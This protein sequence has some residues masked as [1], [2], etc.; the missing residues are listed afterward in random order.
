MQ[1]CEDVR[2]FCSVF[3][4]HL[5]MF[6]GSGPVGT[7]VLLLCLLLHACGGTPDSDRELCYSRQHRD[8]TVNVRLALEQK[9][10]VMVAKAKP[11]EKDCILTCCSEDVGP[12]TTRTQTR[13]PFV[14][15]SRVRS[16][17]DVL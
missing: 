14:A 13:R 10:T 12:G 3:L 5:V 17:A 9:G 4:K 7:S 15:V 16:S 11:S 1:V 8:V 2:L 6:V